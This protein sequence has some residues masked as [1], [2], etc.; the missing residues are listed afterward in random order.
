MIFVDANVFMYFVGTDHPLRKEAWQFFI[1]SRERDV[2]LSRRRKCFR[3]SSTTTC[4]G[5]GRG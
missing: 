1:L 5:T 2:P 4:A 3:N